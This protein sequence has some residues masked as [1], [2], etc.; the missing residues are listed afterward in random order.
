MVLLT[1]LGGSGLTEAL[2]AAIA[3]L[4][5]AATSFVYW[6][7]RRAQ[8]SEKEKEDRRIVS[9]RLAEAD[10][11]LLDRLQTTMN[12]I[13]EAVQDSNVSQQQIAISIAR[14]TGQL[15]RR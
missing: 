7:M 11:I 15:D 9:V 2:S 1:T 10:H 14:L 8:P 12:L 5:G 13:L 6:W 4:V 3:G